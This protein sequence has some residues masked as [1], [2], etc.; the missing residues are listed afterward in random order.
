MRKKFDL[1]DLYRRA[2]DAWPDTLDRQPPL[3]VPPVCPV[4][5]DEL[6]GAP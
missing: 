1:A 3:P 2:L 4:T 5:L 6:L